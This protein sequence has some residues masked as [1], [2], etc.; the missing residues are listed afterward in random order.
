MPSQSASSLAI[1]GDRTTGADAREANVN[2]A[3]AVANVVKSSL[4][5]VGLDQLIVDD[6]G[7]VTIT[8]DGATIL[9]LLDVEHPAA[10]VLV[11]LAELQDAEVGDGTTSVVILAAELLKR[12]NV[13]IQNKIHPTSVI[14]GYRL[15]MREAVRFIEERMTVPV[16]AIS[17]ESLLAVARTSMSSKIIGLG[18]D[19]FANL[20][21]DAITSVKVTNDA[22]ESRYP[23]KA[24]NILK[25]HGRS[26]TESELIKGFSLNC[27]RA[28]DAMPSTV[29]NA[30]I[31]LLDFKLAKHRLHM[32]IQVLV[33]DPTKLEDI[34][35][36][37]YD[38]VREK[39]KLILDAGANVVLTTQTIDDMAL[40]PFVEAGAMAV[41]R[42]KKEDLKRIARIT[43]GTLITSLAGLDGEESFDPVFLG[44]A[45]IVTE[46]R[47]ADDFLINIRGCANTRAC[48]VL[49]R[50]PNEYALDESERSLHDTLCVLKRTLESSKVTVGG[51]CVDA[52]L[53]IA[54]ENFATTLGSKAQMAIAEFS[55]ALLILPK[56]LAVNAACDA[57]DLIARL[58]A[59]HHTSQTDADQEKL[60]WT[61]LDL[62]TG[63]VRNNLEAGVLEPAKL[64]TK[65]IQ[66]ATEACITILRI[67]DCIRLHPEEPQGGGGH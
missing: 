28:T 26:S 43:G 37:E 9:K 58:R 11:E 33:D 2:A 51:G 67:D 32:G 50:G 22:G 49:L 53:S 64:K 62:A 48:S 30:K 7:D 44:S 23:I 19:F 8:N 24:I 21:V 27:R 56:T 54:L 16:E 46:E 41:R 38:I 40:K 65:Q 61:G 55:S 3:S 17:R 18:A 25:A 66:F 59:Y 5:P 47:V 52:A 29:K 34:R 57:T 39:I 31:A 45:D 35:K 42:C 1:A 36:R 6:V 14:S 15:A 20:A 13:L 60:K 4:G 63:K 12:A 10:K